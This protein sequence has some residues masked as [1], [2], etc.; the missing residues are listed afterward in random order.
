MVVT[1]GVEIPNK[2]QQLSC[3]DVD[4]SEFEEPIENQEEHMTS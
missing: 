2:Q 4:E 3:R 1:V